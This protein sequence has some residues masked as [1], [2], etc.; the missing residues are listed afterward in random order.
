MKHRALGSCLV[1]ASVL[2]LAACAATSSI[3]V[4]ATFAMATTS[5]RRA[6]S[7]LLILSPARSNQGAER[8]CHTAGNCEAKQRWR[9]PSRSPVLHRAVLFS[10]VC[11]SGKR[12]PNR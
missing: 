6:R 3:E 7:P 2:V 5:S 9:E 8:H 10:T 4:A 12:E 11:T 1:F